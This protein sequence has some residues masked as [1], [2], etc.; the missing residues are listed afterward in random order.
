MPI[1]GK[2][3]LDCTTEDFIKAGYYTRKSLALNGLPS[4]QPC[5]GPHKWNL[6]EEEGVLYL[7][8]LTC[9]HTEKLSATVKIH[10]NGQPSTSFDF[11]F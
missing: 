8:C 11:R 7:Y 3:I 5:R 9:Q 4:G 10:R 6:A 2:S 1:G